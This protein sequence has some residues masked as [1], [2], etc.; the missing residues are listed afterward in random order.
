MGQV[1]RKKPAPAWSLQSTAWKYAA[2]TPAQEVAQ[3]TMRNQTYFLELER[4]VFIF[5][6][7]WLALIS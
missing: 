2:E 7:K 5:L 6:L 1:C 3:G 4:L